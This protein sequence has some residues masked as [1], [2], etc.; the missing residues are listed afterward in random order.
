M[1]TTVTNSWV[2]CFKPNPGA[3]L[4]LFCLPYAGGGALIFRDWS[5]QLCEEVEV[6]PIELPG[7]GTRL[8]EKPFT[9]IDPLVNMIAQSLVPYLDKPFAF[10]GHSMGALLSF[11]VTHLLSQQYSSTPAH[12]FVSG[13][14][15]PDIPEPNPPIHPLPNA[16]FLE[17]LRLLNGTPEAVLTNKDLMQL[18]LPT[19]RADFELHETYVYKAKPSL[20]CA[21]TAFGGFQDPDVNCEMLKAWQEQTN[22]TFS[23]QM[24]PG[25]HFFINTEQIALWQSLNQILGVI[26][27]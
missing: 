25:D 13:R 27:Q 8:R 23:L 6:C 3:S 24:F 15:A 18:L 16:D 1:V 12:L 20:R 2:K 9:R 19:L 22:D 14:R 5:D 26:F 4:R 17:E 7:R 10:F 11:E 21:I